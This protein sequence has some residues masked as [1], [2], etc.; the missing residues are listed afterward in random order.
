VQ[1]I[2]ELIQVLAEEDIIARTETARAHHACKLCGK[3]A[4]LFNDPLAELEYRISS[5]CQSC[6]D[7]YYLQEQ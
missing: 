6:Q 1:R 3:P 4:V 7:Y 2:R 5:I